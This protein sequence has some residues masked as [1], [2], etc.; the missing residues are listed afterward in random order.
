MPDFIC[1]LALLWTL[2][3]AKKIKNNPELSLVKD[4]DTSSLVIPVD[5]EI[6]YTPARKLSTLVLVVSIVIN[7]FGILKWGWWIEG[8]AD[9]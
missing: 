2:R 3:Y 8:R 6:A 4:I 1:L 5:E 9:L 7:I